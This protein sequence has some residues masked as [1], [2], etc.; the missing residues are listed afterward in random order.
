MTE[1]PRDTLAEVLKEIDGRT[2]GLP[3]NHWKPEEDEDDEDE[4]RD[5]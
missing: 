2:R 1:P 5:D 4:E 3:K